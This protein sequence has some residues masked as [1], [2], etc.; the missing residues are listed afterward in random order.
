MNLIER[1]IA[2]VSPRRALM[3]AQARHTLEVVARYEAARPT[4]T[5]RTSRDNSTGEVQ[6]TRDAATCRAQARDF[7]RNNDIFR[8]ALHTLARN[9][10]GPT[11][12]SIEPTPRNAND[13]I[14]DD[15]AR[16]LLNLWREFCRSPEVSGTLDWVESQGLV[17]RSWLRDGEVFAQVVEGT[18]APFRYRT[19]VP[20][21]L[22]LLEADH[23]PL[24]YAPNE[25]TEAGI[26]RDAWGAPR[27][28]HVYKQHPGSGR[29]TLSDTALK[30]VPAERMLHLA[31]RE[32]LSGLRGISHFASIITRLH[33]VKDYE[34][35]ERLA[36][37]IAAAIAA[38]VKRDKDMEWTPPNFDPNAKRNF[39][40]RAGAVFDTLL[41]GEDLAMLNPNRPNTALGEFRAQQL[42][43]ASRGATMTYSALSG[44]YNGTYSAQRQELVEGWDGYAMLTWVFVAR[45]VRPVWERFVSHAIAAGQIKVPAGVRRETVAQAAFRGPKMPW[46][47]PLHEAQAVKVMT[48]LGGTSMQQ[49]IAER[50]GRLQDTYEQIARERRL[51]DELGIVLDSD[52]RW[53][54]S[55]GQAQGDGGEFGARDDDADADAPRNPLDKVIDMQNRKG[56]RRSP[57][58]TGIQAS[59]QHARNRPHIEP[60]MQLRPSAAASEYDLLIYGDIGDS[61]WGESVTALSVVQQLIALDAGVT[62]INVRINSYG[63][64]VADGLAIYNALKRHSATKA[65]TV[66]GVAMS[67]A[68]LIAMAGDTVEMPATSILMIHAPWGGIYGNAQELRDYAQVLDTYAEAMADAYVSKSGKD[69]GDVLAL[70]QDGKDH[71]FTGEQAVAEGFADS[72]VDPTESE[73]DENAR[74]FASGLLHRYAVSLPTGMAQMAVTAALRG[75]HAHDAKPKAVPG[76]VLP[77]GPSGIATTHS[78]ALSG[79]TQPAAAGTTPGVNDMTEE[80][81]KAAAKARADVLAA[82]KSRREGIRAQFAPFAAR[83]DIDVAAL[84]RECEDDHDCTPEAAGVKLLAALGKSTT[85]LGG[86][87]RIEAG[88]RD[89]SKTYREGA[90]NALLHRS[91]PGAHKLDERSQDF[92]GF[93]LGDFARD[94]VER[95]GVSTRGM[96]KNEIAVRAMHSTSD[97]PFILENVVTK[98]LRAGYEGT[99]RT[100][101]PFSRRATL[102]DFK[103]I[104]RVQLGGAPNLKRVL[105]GAE[106]EQGTIGDGAE[107]YAVQKYGRI[108]A[109][110][111]E[112]IINDD[113]DALT[114]IPQAFGASAAD[115]ESDLVYA[116]LT[117]NPA[118]SDGKALF[119]ADHGNLG[120]PAGLDD[121]LDPAVANPIAEMRK[122]MLLQKGIEG[123]YI[124]VRPKFLIVP[125]EL[126][127][128]ALKITNATILATKSQDVNVVGPT[129]T[130]IVEPRLHDGSTTAWY[131]AAE[132]STVDTIEYAYLQGH[133]GVFTETKNGFEVDGVQVKCR[134][135]FGAKAIDF[136]GLFKNQGA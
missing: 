67:S 78:P 76:G 125:P 40:L 17:C 90:I 28:F 3:R 128:V 27:T 5:Y 57:L 42:R 75:P 62:K 71:Y 86:G 44:D 83:T 54:S 18:G 1:A 116:I 122:L 84:Q 107:K 52:P 9:I 49:V 51:S 30:P 8:G 77:A 98:S 22:E 130:P 89:E 29:A 101:L 106:Y 91:N 7:E 64:S 60:V 24:D 96:S 32:R 69:R 121:A 13:D 80:E 26:T 95:A 120:A 134:H 109:I 93:D 21:A 20:L 47:N 100:F 14:N 61:W 132:P 37:R 81:K 136:R 10:V 102:P 15:L 129:L 127:E 25:D 16:D 66:D 87:L 34:D 82:D 110:T 2:F 65:V 111:W 133:E 59:L 119:H 94:C 74:A 113:L 115:L 70:L 36:A 114:R 112:T 19:R 50:G 56:L 131:G 45:F 108:V 11:G 79:D 117:G 53:T 41:P 73:P 123:R 46:I 103:Q 12:I 68:S 48:R 39:N 63:G 38:Y 88:T 35:S 4:K 118:M 55:T 23:V 33:D 72:T 105:E 92:R 104:S 6:V 58:S 124:T 135:V 31:I 43:A 97:F 85:P 126:E 99:Q